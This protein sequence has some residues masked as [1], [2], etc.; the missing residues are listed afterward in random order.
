[1]AFR[2]AVVCLAALILGCDSGGGSSATFLPSSQWARSRADNFNS[3]VG[4]ATVVNNGGTYARVVL[5][6]VNG[7]PDP[8]RSTPGIGVEGNVFVTASSGR[9]YGFTPELDEMLW[10]FD[11]ED[12]LCGTGVDVGATSASPSV[13]PFDIVYFG[14]D[15]GYVLS[16]AN[17]IP[18][19]C[20]DLGS[21]VIGSP[22]LIID[23]VEND[24]QAVVVGTADGRVVAIGGD[25]QVRWQFPTGGAV[26]GAI[27]FDG[28]T[29][30]APSADGRL[31]AFTQRGTQAFPAAGLGAVRAPFAPAPSILQQVI[32]V[33]AL[34][35]GT[36][37]GGRMRGISAAGL[38]PLWNRDF[39]F[40][41]A[42]SPTQFQRGVTQVSVNTEGEVTETT[43]AVTDYLLVD[44][45]GNGWLVDPQVGTPGTR[46]IGGLDDQKGCRSDDDCAPAPGSSDDPQCLPI[47]QCV[48]GDNPGIVC[49][50]DM[51]DDCTNG[52]CTPVTYCKG[53]DAVS[54]PCSNDTDCPGGTCDLRLFS[55]G[56]RVEASPIFTGEG[57]LV[58]ATAPADGKGTVYFIDPPGQSETIV[59]DVPT[60][61]T[62]GG[63][64]FCRVA[65]S[66]L[67]FDQVGAVRASPSVNSIGSTYFGDD[68]GVLW[69]ILNE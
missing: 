30:Y 4:A 34:Q 16:V 22:V 29:F 28:L 44:E 61:P 14:T 21:P 40:P 6:E 60:C 27:A 38:T 8:I 9:V 55:V 10:D 62:E 33:T 32:G 63:P 50:S 54:D 43:I 52:T 35:G 15:N 7:A 49:R 64:Q 41:V 13:D 26:N 68:N 24:T 69:V 17:G 11:P 66:G 5:P 56:A 57:T 65:F 20:L 1:M 48:G 25:S 51:P 53:G 3:G 37:G 12:E 19:W 31:Y 47:F 58:V 18:L 23:T 39:E 36:T 2:L 42:T 67:G 46:C 45:V 59:P